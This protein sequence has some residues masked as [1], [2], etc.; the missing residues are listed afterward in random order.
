MVNIQSDGDGASR[1][2]YTHHE[3]DFLAFS[4]IG[5]PEVA[6]L[7]RKREGIME[8][9]RTMTKD[10]LTEH[11]VLGI[12]FVECGNAEATSTTAKELRLLVLVRVCSP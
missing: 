1:T 10:F 11:H 2:K 4:N 5:L 3:C 7:G 8:S 6:L 12:C 9:L